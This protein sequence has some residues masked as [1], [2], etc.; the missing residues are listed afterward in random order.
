MT[1]KTIKTDV[2]LRLFVRVES[3]NSFGDR[4]AHVYVQPVVLARGK[5]GRQEYDAYDVDSYE[6]DGVPEGVSALKGLRV[7]AQMDTS[8]ARGASPWYAYRVHFDGGQVD[9]REAER[10]L[11]ILRRLDKRMTVLSDRYGYPRDLET[12]LAHLADALGLTGQ[13]FVR[14]V[15]AEADYEGHG[16]RSM[17][18]DSLRYWLQDQV[19]AFRERYGIETADAS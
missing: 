1:T 14:R 8:T 16:H 7:K 11:P 5:F 9:V 19:K 17:T 13:P 3:S 18:V 6:I 15:D 10:I 4:Y 12:F 2:D